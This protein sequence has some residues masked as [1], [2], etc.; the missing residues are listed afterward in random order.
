[1]VAVGIIELVG[2]I[3]VISEITGEVGVEVSLWTFEHPARVDANTTIKAMGLMVF[4]RTIISLFISCNQRQTQGIA[5]H[6]CLFLSRTPRDHP[7]LFAAGSPYHRWS[8][9]AWI[10]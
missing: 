2:G 1:M 7:L 10:G 5:L 4:F 6:R 8:G 3:D 9:S